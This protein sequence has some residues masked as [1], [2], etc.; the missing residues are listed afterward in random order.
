MEITLDG[1]LFTVL[2]RVQVGYYDGLIVSSQRRSMFSMSAKPIVDELLFVRS[3]SW[4]GLFRLCVQE[5][6]QDGYF[7]KGADYT[8]S[9][10]AKMELQLHF[11]KCYDRMPVVKHRA[12]EHALC[13]AALDKY[14]S[15]A[16]DKARK[17][18]CPIGEPK[19]ETLQKIGSYKY[20]YE[21]E[22]ATL[23]DRSKKKEY[24]LLPPAEKRQYAAELCTQ[25]IVR[26]PTNMFEPTRVKLSATL[27]CIELGGACPTYFYYSLIHL[28][29]KTDQGDN[30]VALANIDERGML[31]PLITVPVE[32]E[33]DNDCK[34]LGLYSQYAEN[35]SASI[36][37]V[38]EYV[39]MCE[40]RG[41]RCTN[42]YVL[43]REYDAP[44]FEA[45]KGKTLERSSARSSTRSSKG[46]TRSSQGSTRSSHGSN[47]SSQGSNRSSQGSKRSSKKAKIST[48]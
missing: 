28:K 48:E 26:D 11:F 8:R 4:G 19:Y 17:I 23:C 29:T 40:R 41:A 21:V 36:A 3:N 12:V 5:P 7:V 42:A 37:K 45:I 25:D 24:D 22:N 38:L 16:Q 1:V 14:P 15:K 33:L 34:L 47:R 20:N 2:E 39:H 27:Y 46:S 35:H 30:P 31:V 18:K 13:L 32:E 6:G 43:N 44:F 10:F 9:T